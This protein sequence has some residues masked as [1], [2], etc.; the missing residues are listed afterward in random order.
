M[1]STNPTTA[2][3]AIT[4]VNA[5]PVNPPLLLVEFEEAP[6]VGEELEVDVETWPG[7]VENE[8]GVVAEEEEE[9]V[10]EESEV[11]DCEVCEL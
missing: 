1:S 4:A 7:R 11:D 3:T 6:F 2:D 9:E 8:P 10:D 5:D